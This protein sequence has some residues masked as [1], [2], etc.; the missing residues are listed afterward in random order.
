MKIL[1]TLLVLATAIAVVL[2]L[3]HRLCSTT[4][5]GESPMVQSFAA[6][7]IESLADV[8]VANVPYE[9][10]SIE[11]EG[12]VSPRSQGGWP[13]KDEK[14]EVH[15]FELAAWRIPGQPIMERDLLLLRPVRLHAKYF[16]D[17]P[18]YTVHRMKVLLSEDHTRA[19]LEKPLPLTKADDQLVAIAGELQKPVVINTKSFGKLVLD[20]KLDWFEGKA[21]WQG[22]QI[23]VRFP[24]EDRKSIAG[25]ALE[26]AE[27]IWK[28]QAKWELK[29]NNLII[30][31]LLSLK[32]SNWRDDNEATLTEE[33]FIKRITLE[34]AKFDTNGKFEFW[35]ADGELFLGHAIEVLG[36][37]KD[38]PTSAGISG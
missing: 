6:P 22:R 26:T 4:G 33:A 35:Y 18:A 14:F 5:S 27:T 8:D 28:D 12:V 21:R 11:L 36:N 23:I 7:N 10:T 30:A 13:G 37:L 9:S 24:T 1:I 32:N 17:Y 15:S 38:G 2:I 3:R 25:S 31:E 20:R 16:S 29:V 19:V 34:S